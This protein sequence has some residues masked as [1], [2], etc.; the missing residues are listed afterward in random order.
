MKPRKSIDRRGRS[1]KE[2]KLA[3][4]D[5]SIIIS[6]A[7]L[8]VVSFLVSL[9]VLRWTGSVIASAAIG[10]M[11]G[12]AATFAVDAMHTATERVGERLSDENDRSSS[13]GIAEHG[14]PSREEDMGPKGSQ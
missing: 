11:W 7:V 10:T 2:A 5:G 8:I 4:I 14:R 3:K 12:L 9:G 6:V 13:G 1:L